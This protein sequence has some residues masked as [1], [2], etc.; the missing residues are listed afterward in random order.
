[1][2][3]NPDGTF[4]RVWKFVD[5]FVSGDKVTRADLD[6]AIDDL[7]EPIQQSLVA[8][9]EMADLATQVR[10]DALSSSESSQSASQ[11]AARAEDAENTVSQMAETVSEDR[12]TTRSYRD[13][14]LTAKNEAVEAKDASLNAQQASE[15]AENGAEAA[16][17]GAE[18]ARDAAIA[19]PSDVFASTADAL[20]QGVVG[21]SGI[22]AGSGGTDGVFDL[23]FSG[24]GGSGAVGKFVVSG[25]AL[26]SITIIFPGVNFTSAPSPD[27]SAS[28]GLTGAS[29]TL[30]LG[31]VVASGRYFAVPNSNDE[32][33]IDLYQNASG[34]ASF[35][36]SMPSSEALKT[37]TKEI[38]EIVKIGHPTS[39]LGAGTNTASAS[40]FVFANPML[41]SGTVRK[42]SFFADNAGPLELAAWSKSGD[43]FTKQRSQTITAVAGWQEVEIN[44]PVNSGERL[45]FYGN[46][47]VSYT[48]SALADSGGW[49]AGAGDS[50]TDASASAS[51]RLHFTFEVWTP[52]RLDKAESDIAG[53][54]DAAEFEEMESD[55]YDVLVQRIGSGDPVVDGSHNLSAS[56]FAL[57]EPVI[58]DGVLTNFSCF[59]SAAGDVRV[60]IF[61]RVG[62]TFTIS[63]E[64]TVSATGGSE[65]FSLNMPVL[66]G[67][68][69][70]VFGTKVRFMA[71]ETEAYGW[72]AGAGPTSFTDDTASKTTPL[73]VGFDITYKRLKD[74]SKTARPRAVDLPFEYG[75]INN[76]GQSLGEGSQTATSG[77][78]PI[79]T[80]QEYDNLGFA[81]YPT[82]PSEPQPAT[83]ANTQKATDRG[84]FPG[85]GA[86]SAIRAALLRDND[87]SYQDVKSTLVV[88]NNAQSGRRIDQLSK[89]SAFYQSALAM[90]EAMGGYLSGKTGVVASLWTQGENDGSAGTSAESYI[91]QMLQL[92]KDYDADF[93]AI[94]GQSK[95]VPLI[96]YQTNSSAYRYIGLAQLE[97]SLQSPLIY[98][99]CPTYMLSYYD[100]VHIDS[101]SA[102]I[103]GAYYGEAI[104]A[105]VMDGEDWQPLRAVDANVLGTTITVT[106]NKSGLVFDTTSM[107]AQTNHG[108][109][110]EDDTGSAVAITSLEVRNGNQVR[111]TCASA[112]GPDWKVRYGNNSVTGKAPYGG[113]GGNLRDSAGNE[114]TFDGTPLHNWCV[115][116]DWTL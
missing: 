39:P 104:K 46:M 33:F 77:T 43:V 90:A 21:Y 76:T 85:L 100:S 16:R 20:S 14:S 112:P 29:A 86:M 54:L 72:Y 5:R 55:L 88:G 23:A 41:A 56:L 40:N 31:N 4:S 44:L 59:T 50:F 74:F 114:K 107:P 65:S 35:V 69:V 26:T 109:S 111:V 13:E 47:I 24:G 64:E 105:V 97:A 12:D 8:D 38:S 51:S 9:K 1:M 75:F 91:S 89:G 7:V 108:F 102:R 115:L 94:T 57:G 2:P 45:G 99:A 17:A 60:I 116:F 101:V 15:T 80:S 70:G 106:F 110:I 82:A 78:S 32:T 87:L 27:F 6:T 79:T 19:A 10:E 73:R 49:Y 84:E 63:S 34:V 113:G 52:T 28:A 18:A 66:E 67:Q 37:V 103:L 42:V 96:S 92:A 58:S 22:V 83:V 48:A 53:K 3:M 68:H 93:R 95:R 25:G 30:L 62:D 71:G 36:T 81:A 11:S 61:D 98:M